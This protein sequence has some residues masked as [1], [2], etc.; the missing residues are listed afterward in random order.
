MEMH[1]SREIQ[2]PS[3]RVWA[4]LTDLEG[5]PTTLSGVERVERLDGGNGFAVGTRW[6]ETRVMFGREATEEME[7]TALLDGRSYT[8]TADGGNTNYTSVLQV[9][10]LDGERCRLSMSFSAAPSGIAAK[11]LGATVG[12]LFQKATR[13]MLQRDLDDI[14][15]RAEAAPAE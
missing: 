9:E 14:A 10:P 13:T 8:V 12:R 4:I 6:R 5:S 11:L 1:V 3:E 15:R 7:V 2:A